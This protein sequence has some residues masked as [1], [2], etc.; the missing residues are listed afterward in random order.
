MKKN[1]ESQSDQKII[2]ILS[3]DHLADKAVLWIH[4]HQK[5][6]WISIATATILAVVV[7][8]ISLSNSRSAHRDFA[9]ADHY[10]SK[11]IAGGADAASSYEELLAILERRGELKPLYQGRICQILLAQAFVTQALPQGNEALDRASALLPKEYLQFSKITLSIAQGNYQKSLEDS[12]AL[13]TDLTQGS[14]IAGYNQI[15]LAMLYKE[16]GNSE[17]E[18]ESWIAVE[19]LQDESIRENFREGTVSLADFIEARRN[20]LNPA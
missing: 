4:N 15:R 17:K 2:E 9:E 10:Y 11:W 3:D 20:A 18:L 7:F 5:K 8:A 16:L 14:A 1:E 13:Q 6:L 12:I 19:K